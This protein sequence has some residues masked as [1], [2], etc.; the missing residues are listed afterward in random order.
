MPK[1]NL[2][3]VED[4]AL[5]RFALKTAFESCDYNVFEAENAGLAIECT[6]H[7][8]ID[9]ILMDLGLPDFNGIET[10]EKI[11]KSHPNIKVLILTSHEKKEEVLDSLKAG[12]SA[13]CSKDINPDKLIEIVK[14]VLNG[15]AWFDAKVAQYV[16]EAASSGSKIHHEDSNNDSNLTSR[17]KQVL[18]LIVEGFNNQDIAKKLD[19]SI[20]TTK[21]HVCNILQKLSVQDRTQAAIKALKDNII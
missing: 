21:A 18:G 19:V 8:K 15:D 9:V 4:H 11:K 12:A 17:E 14:S 6:N 5:T 2:L 7:N 1:Y 3:I 10:T 20:N 16:I 13:Y